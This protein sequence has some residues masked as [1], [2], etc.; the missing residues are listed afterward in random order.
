MIYE[1]NKKIKIGYVR[2]FKNRKKGFVY[3]TIFLYNCLFN[4]IIKT[5]AGKNIIFD[6]FINK[7]NLESKKH[8]KKTTKKIESVIKRLNFEINKSKCEAIVLSRE[9]KEKLD[10]TDFLN[11][12]M[13][14]KNTVITGNI[15]KN[16]C[17]KIEVPIL[18]GKYLM[19]N[20]TTKIVEKICILKNNEIALSSIH[21]LVKKNSKE[22][23][24]IIYSLSEK[25]RT[26]NLI[27]PNIS[28]FKEIEE[29]LLNNSGLG[30]SIANN[31]KKSLKKAEIIINLDIENEII[32]KYNIN[33]E[34]IIINCQND[35]LELGPVFSGVIVNGIVLDINKDEIEYFEM[36]DLIEKFDK[37]ELYESL[38]FRKNYDMIIQQ[39]NKNNLII[40]EF[41]GSR[42]I[43]NITEINKFQVIQIYK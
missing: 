6:I 40:K 20:L 22:N 29:N 39:T 3:K 25:V 26:I 7:S 19:K 18:N 21:I 1:P 23:L 12:G 14:E 41:V 30:I 2:I 32:K 27:T 36:Y 9:I 38:I 17:E 31:R 11:H 10:L 43:I 5:T 28:S 15:K 24:D 13:H 8:T 16:V 33:R 42:G 4:R 35:L 34:A 37:T